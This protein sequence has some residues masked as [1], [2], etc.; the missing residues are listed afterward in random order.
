MNR[1]NS[2]ALFNFIAPVYR[3]FYQVQ[4]RQFQQVLSTVLPELDL[5]AY[6]TVLDTIKEGLYGKLSF[7][8]KERGE[9]F[10][11]CE[12]TETAGIEIV[13]SK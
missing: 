11:R 6:E 12:T 7:C 4:K 9:N 5:T 8:L 13:M 2:V 1:E 3:M 10:L